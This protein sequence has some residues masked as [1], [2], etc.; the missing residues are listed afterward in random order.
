MKEKDKFRSGYVCLVGETNVGKSTIVNNMIGELVSIVTPKPQTTR[1]NVLGIDTTDKYQII[2]IDSPG[3]HKGRTK[4]SKVM[5]EESISTIM[6]ADIVLHVVDSREKEI[7]DL[8]EKIIAEIKKRK[9][10][11]IL[12][13]TKIDVAKKEDVIR[14]IQ[15]YSLLLDYEAII[16]V[17]TLKEKQSKKDEIIKEIYSCLPIGPMYYEEEMFTDQSEREIAEEIIRLKLLKFLRE[18]IPHG[19]YIE[20]EKY[21][22]RKTKNKEDIVDIEAIIFTNKQSHKGIIIGKDGET[23]KKIGMYSRQDLE[24]MINKKVNLKLWVKVQED[25]LNLD[26]IVKKFKKQ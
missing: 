24:K 19:I 8:N 21:K 5:E 23:L 1:K 22:Q 4:L 18:E 7:S 17:N 9:K 10:K 2:Y 12:I 15:K 6:D 13:L 25:W 26:K 20:V 3:L 16:P 11:A 14:N